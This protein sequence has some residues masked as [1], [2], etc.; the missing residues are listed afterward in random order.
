VS[1]TGSAARRLSTI[2]VDQ[3]ISGASNILIAVLAARLLD[4]AHFGR[5]GLVLLLYGMM[6]SANRALIGGPLLVHPEEA[7]ERTGEVVGSGLVVGIVLAAVVL[8]LG[9]L[10]SVWDPGLGQAVMVLAAFTPLL[11]L[12]D[13]GRFLGFALQRP[14]LALRLDVAWLV[15]LLAGVGLLSWWDVENLSWFV[16]AWAGS[17]AV[18]GLGVLVRRDGVLP[19]MSLGWLRT[20]WGYSWRYL[21]GSVATQGSMLAGSAGVAAVAG[22][23]ELGRGIGAALLVRPFMTFQIAAMAS[24]VSDVANDRQDRATV[25]RHVRRT[26]AITTAIAVVNTAIML[27]LP[28]ALGRQVLGE[29][30]A[31]AQPL[32]LAVGAQIVLLGLIT[33]P[34]TALL[35]TGVVRVSIPLDIIGAL[36]YTVLMVI[37]AVIDG[38]Y[39]AAWAVA[40]GLT[41]MTVV[42]WVALRLHHFDD[43]SQD[44]DTL[45]E[46]AV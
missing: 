16:V 21:V 23:R 13:L 28:D 45:G 20:T 42:W 18:A 14:V 19:R 4:T 7:R 17:G 3:A 31:A 2:T 29:T 36:L 25:M 26:T 6:Q 30:W 32:L 41:V 33:G 46:R 9:L 10:T 44:A 43:V 1:G 11:V 37:G 27:V 12:Q 34:R 39:G 38:A 15:L 24:G 5:F 35:G 22:A 40:A 8:V